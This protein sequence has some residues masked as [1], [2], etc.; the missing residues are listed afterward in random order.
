MELT[1]ISGIYKIVNINNEKVY[2]GSSKD[3]EKRFK[4]HIYQLKNNIHHSSKLQRSFNKTKDKSAFKLEIIE[5]VDEDKLKEREEYYIDLYNAFNNG[6]NCCAQVDNPKFSLKNS[7]K[8][9][10][11]K[12]TDEFYDEFMKFYEQYKDNLKIGNKFLERL[13]NKHYKYKTYVKVINM[14]KW[15]LTNYNLYDYNANFYVTTKGIYYLIINDL[16]G[17]EIEEVRF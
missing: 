13:I 1:K 5:E 12:K 17:K 14:I 4:E 10:N 2:I 3:I 15:A 6:Y 11:K 9:I 7:K 16:N 8:A